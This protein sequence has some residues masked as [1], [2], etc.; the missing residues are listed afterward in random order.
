MGSI[1]TI[2]TE[3]NPKFSIIG[4]ENW[5]KEFS[6]LVPHEEQDDPIGVHDD[7]MNAQL[8]SKKKHRNLLFPLHII[9]THMD[10][11]EY[12]GN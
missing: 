9:H 12:C 5:E 8:P 1:S 11:V 4:D 2:G 7:F 3:E 6:L 10:W